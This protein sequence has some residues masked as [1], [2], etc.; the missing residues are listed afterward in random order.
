[1]VCFSSLAPPFAISLTYM[2][3]DI[4]KRRTGG[5]V[6]LYYKSNGKKQ[7]RLPHPAEV[8]SK[9]AS[10]EGTGVATGE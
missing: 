10:A 8:P 7:L 9:E 5:D 1:M 2:C 3:P 6:V 4:S